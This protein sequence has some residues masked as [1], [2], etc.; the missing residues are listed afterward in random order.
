MP[1]NHPEFYVKFELVRNK[2]GHLDWSEDWTLLGQ[3]DREYF[4]SDMDFKNKRQALNMGPTYSQP[5][6]SPE[7]HLNDIRRFNP[8]VAIPTTKKG[9]PDIGLPRELRR[10]PSEKQDQPAPPVET[11]TGVKTIETKR[12]FETPTNKAPIESD[13]LVLQREEQI[14]TGKDSGVTQELKRVPKI[15]NPKDPPSRPALGASQSHMPKGFVEHQEPKKVPDITVPQ[16]TRT[17]TPLASGIELGSDKT[18]PLEKRFDALTRSNFDPPIQPPNK[19]VVGPAPRPIRQIAARKPRIITSEDL[20]KEPIYHFGT[21][22]LVPATVEPP[23]LE[24]KPNIPKLLRIPVVHEGLPV[25]GLVVTN[26]EYSR[27][28]QTDCQLLSFGSMGFQNFGIKAEDKTAPDRDLQEIE[29]PLSSHRIGVG[30]CPSLMRQGNWKLPEAA[31]WFIDPDGWIYSRGLT[32]EWRA[33]EILRHRSPNWDSY[34]G[35][36]DGQTYFHLPEIDGGTG[37]DRSRTPHYD[38]QR[39]KFIP[40]EKTGGED[41]IGPH[42]R[43]HR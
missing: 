30:F 28:L 20:R 24:K 42:N 17:T 1:N 35:S 11:I 4:E 2:I 27:V 3:E 33:Q 43:K 31:P 37:S 7:D 14:N 38:A 40:P 29:S 6:V 25:P 26:P 36:A 34:F 9:N 19:E 13:P 8:V 39:A 22:S 10:D 18:D 21:S 41:P 23:G 5:A 12:G 15:A 32:Q 16:G